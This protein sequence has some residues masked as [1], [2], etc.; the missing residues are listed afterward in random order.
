EIDAERPVVDFERALDEGAPIVHPEL[1]TN[2]G[3]E[4]AFPVAPELET[5]LQGDNVVRRTFRQQRHTPVPMETRGIVVAYEAAG[6]E[7]HAWMSTQNPHEVKHAI[8]RVAG[9]PS[10]LVRVEARDV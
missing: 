4:M 5:L 1:G 3:A 7:L 8:S 9:V 10:H 6:G 2:L